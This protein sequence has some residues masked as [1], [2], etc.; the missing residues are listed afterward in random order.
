[1]TQWPASSLADHARTYITNPV[2]AALTAELCSPPSRRG[3]KSASSGA[4]S[5]AQRVLPKTKTV[6]GVAIEFHEERLD[7]VRPVP[8]TPP[9]HARFSFW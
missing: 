4:T 6:A 1:M 5:L 8:S 3:V 9:T 2:E 7:D